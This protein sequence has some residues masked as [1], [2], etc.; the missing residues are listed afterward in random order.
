METI[1]V[2]VVRFGDRKYLQMQY[3]DSVTG[4]K[5]T[6]STGTANRR[7]AERVAA[8]WEAVLQAGRYQP[9]SK[10][11]W[12]EF[13]R[14]YEDEVLASLADTTDKKAA[15]VFNAVE[16]I[17]NPDRVSQMTA[18]KISYLQSRLRQKGLK[19]STIKGHM[20]H[21]QA[22]LNWAA[23]MQ[24]I[25]VTPAIEMP[26]RAKKSK[27]MKGRP[28]TYEEFERMLQKAPGIVH[29][30]AVDSWTH[31]LNGMW[32]SGLRLEE[33]LELWWD[34]DDQLC[35]DTTG[36]RVKLRIPAD[37]EK[38]N[39]DR[40]LPLAPEFEEF[41]LATPGSARSGRV[42]K[43]SA[44]RI[45]ATLP[46]AHR[47]G[48]IASEIG[49]AAGVIVARNATKTKFASLHDLR[50]SFGTRWATKV[51]PP[52]LQI[53]MRH[54]SIETTLKYYVDQNADE[55]ADV[56]WKA[57]TGNTSGNSAVEPSDTQTKSPPQAEPA[58][59]LNK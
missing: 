50:R 7:E 59:G 55:A 8:K 37:M 30:H 10:V 25:V 5:K 14:R 34:R 27:V 44:K 51:M 19:E 20:A 56:L 39:E 15:S 42:F 41:L 13:R 49:K 22:A 52:I 43:P 54:D 48:E 18:D 4:R 32:C 58:R 9:P 35:V 26:K 11:T 53:L 33:S 36:R 28:I 57:V 29:A 38:G 31:Y 12:D 45:G 16:K 40:V 47:V 21:L 24:I 1:S 6:R 3:R 17:L 46:K 23:R 2:N